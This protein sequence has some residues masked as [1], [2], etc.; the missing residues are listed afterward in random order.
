[1]LG[2]EPQMEVPIMQGLFVVDIM[3]QWRGRQVVVE[4]DGPMHYSSN[5]LRHPLCSTVARDSDSL[6][7]QAHGLVVYAGSVWFAQSLSVCM[8][9]GT[10]SVKYFNSQ[11][12]DCIAQRISQLQTPAPYRALGAEPQMEVPIMQGLFVVDIMAQWRGRQVVVE[13]DGPMHYSS[14]ALRHPLCSTVAR[15]RCLLDLGRNLLC[16]HWLDWKHVTA[17]APAHDASRQQQAQMAFLHAQLDRAIA[18]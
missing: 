4:V 9:S 17:S 5:A 11:K 1:A 16:V 18:V 8:V 13:V 6:N 10:L 14:N 3:A 2:A 7:I 12:D 15:D